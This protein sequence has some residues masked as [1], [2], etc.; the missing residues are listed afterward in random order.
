VAGA[1]QGRPAEAQL[2]GTVSLVDRFLDASTRQ[3][4]IGVDVDNPKGRLRPGQ[5]VTVVIN[6]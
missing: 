2:P 4:R 1:R 6:P 5:P 3:V